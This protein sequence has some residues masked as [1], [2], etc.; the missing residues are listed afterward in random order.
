MPHRHRRLDR[1]LEGGDGARQGWRHG[2]WLAEDQHRRYRRLR[3]EVLEAERVLRARGECRLLARQAGDEAGVR[4][5]HR[6]EEH[7]SEL[8]SLMRISYA[9][10]CLKKKINILVQLTMYTT[11]I[12]NLSS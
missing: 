7:T 8:Q 1:R 3:A 5:A 6:S 11:S 10:F 2:L 9:V 12:L 4:A